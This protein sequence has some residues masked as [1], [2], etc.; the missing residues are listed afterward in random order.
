MHQQWQRFTYLTANSH[1][2]IA[3]KVFLATISLMIPCYYLDQSYF[4]VTAVLGIV[5]AAI[6]EGDDS[7]RQRFKCSCITLITFTLS[8][9]VITLLFPYPALFLPGLCL[10]SFSLIILGSIGN[11]YVSISFAGLIIGVYTMLGL[12]HGADGYRY[13]LLLVSGALWYFTLSL[14]LL[15]FTLYNPTREK[16]ATIYLALAQYQ[17]EKAKFFSDEEHDHKAIRHK[18]STL[19]INI[20]NALAECRR[21]LDLHIHRDQLSPEL[22]RFIHLYQEAQELH[23]K[24]TS[25]HFHYE[26]LNNYL[27]NTLVSAGFEQVLN[28]LADACHDCGQAILHNREYHYDKGLNWTLTILNKELNSLELPWNI[29]APLKLLFK[30]L[31]QVNVLLTNTEKPLNDELPQLSPVQK[32]SAFKQIRSSLNLASPVFRHAIRLTLGIAISYVIIQQSELHGYWVILTTLFVVQP[33]YSATRVKLGQ[34]IRGTLTGIVI[35]SLLLYVFPAERGQLF[36]LA[37]SAFLFF[38]YLRQDYSKAVSFITLLVLFAFN[39]LY[40]QGYEVALPRIIDTLTGCLIAF[41]LVKLVLPN[42]QYKQFPKRLAEAVTANQK[43]FHEIIAQYIS[44]KNNQL[45]YRVS[46]RLAYVADSHLIASWKEMQI[47]PHDKRKKLNHVYD[48]AR[49]NHAMLSALSALGVHRK[50]LHDTAM[51]DSLPQIESLMAQSFDQTRETLINAGEE[52]HLYSHEIDELLCEHKISGNKNT[53]LLVQKLS[54]IAVISEEL[55]LMAR[56]IQ[57]ESATSGSTG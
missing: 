5:A 1:F 7:Y 18:L 3:M 38:Y 35:G 20:V 28:Q 43:Y 37:G 39:V 21:N 55:Q 16:L 34:R 15:G 24:I 32:K 12:D 31:A 14:A 45:P 2:F 40:Q 26:S 9:F 51:R 41:I 8:S 13:S 23:E 10:L 50:Q 22:K 17:R 27:T 53:A 11:R 54:Q 52:T 49:R 29:C 6:S 33:S 25:S 4:S 48:I 42:W 46:R 47:E 30:N 19:N 44:G 36:M 57:S 56:E